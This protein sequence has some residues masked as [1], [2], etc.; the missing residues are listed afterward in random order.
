MDNLEYDIKELLKDIGEMV[1]E[2]ILVKQA[3]SSGSDWRTYNQKMANQI[4]LTMK[5]LSPIIDKSTM[6]VLQKSMRGRKSCLN[7]RQKVTILVVKQLLGRSNRGMSYMLTLFSSMSGSYL[8]Y[9]SVERLYSDNQVYLALF[10]MHEL[11]SDQIG[12]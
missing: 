1:R 11:L 12:A 10:K 7:L 5:A 3:T 8:G 6:S 9:K 2:N 4:K